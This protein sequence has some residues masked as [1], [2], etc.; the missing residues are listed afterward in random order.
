MLRSSSLPPSMAAR[1][2][3]NKLLGPPTSEEIHSNKDLNSDL[4]PRPLIKRR[5]RA[6]QRRN[7]MHCIPNFTRSHAK[8]EQE[9]QERKNS[10]IST[11]TEPFKLHMS[12]RKVIF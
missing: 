2:E 11:S 3:I 5:S 9:L 7:K 10:N 6:R 8:I 12:L 1:E 4:D